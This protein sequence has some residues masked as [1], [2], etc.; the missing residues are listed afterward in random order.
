MNMFS[1]KARLAIAGALIATA[2]LFGS[3]SPVAAAD[4]SV[5]LRGDQ[6]VP[7]VNTKATGS[8]TITIADDKSVRGTI[9]T[10]GITGTMAHIHQAAPGANGPPIITLTKKADNVWAVP[11][12][13]KLTDAQYDAFKAG[14]LYVNVHTAANPNGEVR[15]QLKP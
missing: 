5:T 10:S 7:P 13:A 2:S 15:G 14:N 4:I 9:S 1:S 6:E 8:G 3:L 12:G 11:D